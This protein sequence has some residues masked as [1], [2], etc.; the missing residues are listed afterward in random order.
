MAA[1]ARGSLLLAACLVYWLLHYSCARLSG[2]WITL[3]CRFAV[4]NFSSSFHLAPKRFFPKNQSILIYHPGASPS[5]NNETTHTV[6]SWYRAQ[7]FLPIPDQSIICRS[8]FGPYDLLW[9]TVAPYLAPWFLSTPL[10]S[11]RVEFVRRG[12][13]SPTFT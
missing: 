11:R 10:A 3:R 12:S 4:L 8:V 5:L 13:N 2:V 9:P 7:S 1:L 6:P